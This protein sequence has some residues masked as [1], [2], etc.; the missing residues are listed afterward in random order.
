M[1]I[2]YR[3]S[4]SVVDGEVFGVVIV[5]SSSKMEEHISWNFIVLNRSEAV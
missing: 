4:C 5:G 2:Q 1:I 3:T